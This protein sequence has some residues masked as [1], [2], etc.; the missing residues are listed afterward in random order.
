MRYSGIQPQY[1]PR[2]HY[3]ARILN[4]D[5]FMIRDDAQ[6]VRKHKYPNGRNDKSYQAHTPI[7]QSYG[8]QL[9]SIPMQHSEERFSPI[10]D[11]KLHYDLPWA[12]DHL[13]ALKI[14]YSKSKNFKII[15]PKIE[16]LLQIT[17]DTLSDL[18]NAT[19]YW[20]ILTL[21][22]KKISFNKKFFYS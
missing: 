22:E 14:A 2:L 9:L 15:F 20:G 13:F 17:Y 11:T 21:L 4:A 1:F 7:K 10:S 6:F 5:I 3:F 12:K 8:V 19:I 16:E 18:N